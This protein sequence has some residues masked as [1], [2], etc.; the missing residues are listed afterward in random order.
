MIDISDCDDD[1][2]SNFSEQNNFEVP[3]LDNFDEE[4]GDIMA[5]PSLESS[6]KIPRRHKRN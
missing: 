2:I 6:L 4:W 5:P 1:K 3:N